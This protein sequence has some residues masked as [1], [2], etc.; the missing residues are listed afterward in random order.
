[1]LTDDTGTPGNGKFE[2]NLGAT[3]AYKRRLSKD[4][5]YQTPQLDANYGLGDRTELTWLQ[6]W[7]IHHSV[8]HTTSDIGPT[9]LGLKYR[10]YDNDKTK[11]TVSVYPQFVFSP[12]YA[13]VKHHVSD[14]GVQVL[15]PVQ[16]QKQFKYFDLGGEM[17]YT[18]VTE[19][20][21]I[22]FWGVVASRQV[23][24]RLEMLG[25][26]HGEHETQTGGVGVVADVASRINLV[27][28][29]VKLMLLAGRGFITHRTDN[30]GFFGYIGF[31]F[32]F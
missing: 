18:V 26:M 27:D 17:G 19:N 30:S 2:I 29:K 25:E 21:D 3:M 32:N 23:T 12:L 16:C 1:M 4:F 7:G 14:P 9:L 28:E 11:V 24:K 6:P 22:A 31:Q 8:D 20:S 13:S 10:F 15:L 5:D